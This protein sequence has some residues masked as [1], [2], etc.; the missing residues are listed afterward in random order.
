MPYR[1]ALFHNLL[2]WL[3]RKCLELDH[4]ESINIAYVQCIKTSGIQVWDVID[5]A[6]SKTKGDFVECI[7]T[8][9][10]ANT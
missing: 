6:V 7:R 5:R 4:F 2:N 3:Q 8:F 10:S 1:P 9:N